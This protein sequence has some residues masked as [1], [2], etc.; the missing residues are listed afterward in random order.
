MKTYCTCGLRRAKTDR[1]DAIKIADFGI[2]NW[3]RLK[4]IMLVMMYIQN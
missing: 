3:Y 2:N 4:N 1:Q